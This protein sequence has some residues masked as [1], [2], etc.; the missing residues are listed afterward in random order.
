MC[1]DLKNQVNWTHPHDAAVPPVLLELLLGHSAGELGQVYI[2]IIGKRPGE[3]HVGLIDV[4]I[5]I[6]GEN[7]KL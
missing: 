7:R 1:E 4:D 6:I 2:Y 3:K 5:G